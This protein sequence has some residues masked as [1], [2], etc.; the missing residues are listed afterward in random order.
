MARKRGPSVALKFRKYRENWVDAL[1]PLDRISN[2]R[3]PESLPEDFDLI[4]PG[5]TNSVI[6]VT[7]SKPREAFAKRIRREFAEGKFKFHNGEWFV[8]DVEG[9]E[10][11]AVVDATRFQRENVPEKYLMRSGQ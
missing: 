3:Q 10:L 1:F 8:V 9:R 5:T 7:K 6:T 2:P 4:N 11:P